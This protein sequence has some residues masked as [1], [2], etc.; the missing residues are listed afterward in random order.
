MF[1]SY[2]IAVT[3]HLSALV[4]PHPQIVRRGANWGRQGG[5]SD[6]L[7]RVV[8][9]HHTWS[10]KLSAAGWG[11]RQLGLPRRSNRPTECVAD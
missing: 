2:S 8:T 1:G 11:N 7:V 9:Q 4:Q 6:G 10:L 3:W 5:I